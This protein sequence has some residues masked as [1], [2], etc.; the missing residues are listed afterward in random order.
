MRFSVL[1]SLL[2]VA[3]LSLVEASPKPKP[4]VKRVDATPSCNGS[5]D[6]CGLHLMQGYVF[7]GTHNS[8]TYILSPNPALAGISILRP[9]SCTTECQ[10]KSVAQQF[11]DG[12][13]A[14]HFEMCDAAHAK[15]NVLFFN[16]YQKRFA[17]PVPAYTDED[18]VVC[19]G[20]DPVWAYGPLLSIVFRDLQVELSKSN[21]QVIR[22]VLEFRQG[23]VTSLLNKAI[24]CFTTIFCKDDS[25][26][27]LDRT[28]P[29]PIPDITETPVL[30]SN[31]TFKPNRCPIAIQFSEL[32]NKNP[33]LGEL[34]A[35]GTNR[36]IFA[37]PALSYYPTDGSL[38]APQATHHTL[39]WVLQDYLACRYDGGSNL[40]EH[41]KY[42]EWQCATDATPYLCTYYSPADQIVY[43]KPVPWKLQ[44]QIPFGVNAE[45]CIGIYAQLMN[46]AGG[47]IDKIPGCCTNNIN[48]GMIELDYYSFWN[49]I[50]SPQTDFIKWLNKLNSNTSKAAIW[51]TV[52]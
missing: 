11:R 32:Y 19:H 13:R 49:H 1:I 2:V 51:G 28:F 7:P 38:P 20:S 26:Y 3:G 47:I 12:V 5:P 31:A 50:E 48:L 6:N 9:L 8:A 39:P 24:E 30:I 45:V 21:N 14:F 18:P 41:L 15:K 43:R 27:V 52:Y 40:S 23:D 16:L 22:I 29:S 36:I 37:N 35:N 46:G 33:T 34:T 10:D 25:K 44:G 17:S 4:V 42:L